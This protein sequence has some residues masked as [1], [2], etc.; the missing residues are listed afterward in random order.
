MNSYSPSNQ[1]AACPQTSDWDAV[2]S[3]LPPTPNQELCS[4]MTKELSCVV[5]PS[6]SS[7]NYGDLFGYV[8]GHE[9]RACAG[10]AANASTGDYGAYSMCSPSEQLSFAFDQYYKSQGKADSACSFKGAAQLQSATSGGS[11]CKNLIAQAGNGGTGTVTSAPTGAGGAGSSSS[12]AAA[13]KNTVPRPE[14]GLLP[15]AAIVI[16]AGLSGMGIILF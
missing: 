3:P 4:C 15:M 8:C 5:N 9:P 2:A 7:K 12:S 14:S 6:T 1:P 10:I 13:G 16:L 11:S